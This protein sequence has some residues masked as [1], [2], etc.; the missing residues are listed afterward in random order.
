MK[1]HEE[2]YKDTIVR[3]KSRFYG[4]FD[5]MFLNEEYIIVISECPKGSAIVRYRE[6]DLDLRR[7][8]HDMYF[9][10]EG[11]CLR[12]LYSCLIQLDDNMVTLAGPNIVKREKDSTV[13]FILYN[14]YDLKPSAWCEIEMDS[15]DFIKSI[16]II[17]DY[18]KH[19]KELLEEKLIEEM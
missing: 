2:T 3:F 14:E 5:G 7:V 16:D 11:N 4:T 17:K 15:L 9:T 8:N 18:F 1:S 19:E 12:F 6:Y 10:I 13:I